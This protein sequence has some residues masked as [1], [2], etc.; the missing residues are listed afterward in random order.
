M[1]GEDGVGAGTL[2]VH[3]GAG[4]AAAEGAQLQTLQHLS[5]THTHT[6]THAREHTLRLPFTHTHTHTHILGYAELGSVN[7]GKLTFITL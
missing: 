1:D 5:H 2:D 7:T 3:L 4:R 6:H